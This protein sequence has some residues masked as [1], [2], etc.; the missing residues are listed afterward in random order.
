VKYAP[1]GNGTVFSQRWGMVFWNALFFKPGRY[2]PDASKSDE[3]N[4]GAYL[5]E[6]LGHCSMCHT[7]RIGGFMLLGEASG[8]AY[9]GG[10]IDDKV[11][12]DKNRRW[13]A[14]NLTPAKGG[15]AT[16]SVD[17]IVRY[18][19]K[20]FTPARGGSFGPMNEVIVNS[21]RHMTDEDAHAIATY[22]KALPPQE[23]PDA[24]IPADQMTAG[25][26]V[27]KERCEKCHASSGRGGVFNGPPVAGS[28]VVQATDPS[29]L[30]NI[31]L[32]GAK[33]PEALGSFG[34]WETMT[35]YLDVL[36]D[37]EVAAVSNYVRGSW[38][39]KGGP[40]SAGDV[41]KQR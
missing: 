38:K 12:E 41:A 10:T 34:G 35:P 17:D 29:S 9:A 14:V 25:A 4:R 27:Y 32:Y 16:W 24:T 30:I 8:K 13:F 2:Q 40:V 23:L 31:I 26:A 21:M 15:L 6:G 36:S 1:P 18:L 33:V 20:G 19:K 22:L 5:T 39:N 3:W 28:A 7:P 11:T 37:A